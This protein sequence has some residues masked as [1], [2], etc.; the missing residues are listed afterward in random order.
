MLKKICLIVFL[1]VLVIPLFTFTSYAADSEPGDQSK[2]DSILVGDTTPE[3][4]E[5]DVYT[6]SFIN[7]FRYRKLN[8]RNYYE[9]SN[10]VRVSD[11]VTTTAV[12]GS[13]TVNKGV[14]FSTVVSGSVVGLNMSTSK[15]LTSSVGYSLGIEPKRTGYMGYQ[16]YYKVEAG[17]REMFDVSTGKVWE[18]NSYV[19]KVP[20]YGNYKIIY[21]D[22]NAY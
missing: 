20:Q 4:V 12:G 18:R 3:V 14:T 6:P 16:V 9:W 2:K 8:V 5:S 1:S 11:N 13:V 15:A 19:V 21:L 10:F 22:G 7:D 17:T